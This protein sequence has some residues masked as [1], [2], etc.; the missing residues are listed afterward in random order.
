MTTALGT[1]WVPCPLPSGEEPLG[2][3]QPDLLLIQALVAFSPMS[4][5]NP[6]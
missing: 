3:S 6:K 2:D 4:S 1:L 5:Q